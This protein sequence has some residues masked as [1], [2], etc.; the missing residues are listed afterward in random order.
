[1]TRSRR[2]HAE[3]HLGIRDPRVVTLDHDVVEDLAAGV[4]EPQ[5]TAVQVAQHP[6]VTG[7]ATG[8]L[9]LRAAR[10]TRT[11]AASPAGEAVLSR[12]RGPWPAR[13]CG[14]PGASAAG[15][16]RRG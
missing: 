15:A 3:R 16:R 13:T 1:M 2:L 7:V 6:A 5:L 11:V 12:R 10:H 4:A 8:R 9:G 14:G